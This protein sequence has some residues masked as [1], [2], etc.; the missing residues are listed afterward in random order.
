MES[1]GTLSGA[2]LV[3]GRPAPRSGAT[4]TLLV[5][6]GWPADSLSSRTYI[7]GGIRVIRGETWAMWTALGMVRGVLGVFPA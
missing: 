4:A 1:V 6:R 5:C 7:Y 3:V 2:L